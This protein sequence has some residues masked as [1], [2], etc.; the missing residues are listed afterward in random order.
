M[1]FFRHGEARFPEMKIFSTWRNTRTQTVTI[2]LA[3]ERVSCGQARE[4]G[5]ESTPSTPGPVAPHRRANR[6]PRSV[7]FE[8]DVRCRRC[9]WAPRL[10]HCGYYQ[11]GSRK[12]A[13]VWIVVQVTEHHVRFLKA[14]DPRRRAA[15]IRAL[16]SELTAEIDRVRNH[17]NISDAQRIAWP[18]SIVWLAP[19]HK[20]V[21][22][23]E[24]AVGILSARLHG[25]SAQ[26]SQGEN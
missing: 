24:I 18:G 9:L 6:R 20:R 1:N 26:Q 13:F 15:R 12:I 22:I 25:G 17:R 3:V 5:P 4:A 19:S 10:I 16:A 11:G 2:C 14:R 23:D 7:R 21:A 8:M